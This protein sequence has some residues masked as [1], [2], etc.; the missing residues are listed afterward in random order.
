MREAL[1]RQSISL[2]AATGLKCDPWSIFW[3]MNTRISHLTPCMVASNYPLQWPKAAFISSSN[4]KVKP[5]NEPPVRV[6]RPSSNPQCRACQE[7]ICNEIFYG[8]WHH[9]VDEVSCWLHVF[10]CPS[11]DPRTCVTCSSFSEKRTWKASNKKAGI[12][13]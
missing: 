2:Q 3:S 12:L 9:S 4:K 11:L 10:S 1:R 7:L 13:L 6:G 8:C 5:L